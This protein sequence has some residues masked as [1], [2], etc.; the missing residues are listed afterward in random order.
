MPKSSAINF[1]DQSMGKN[2][3]EVF[4]GEEDLEVEDIIDVDEPTQ[5]K[6]QVDRKQNQHVTNIYT[7]NNINNFII[8]SPVPFIQNPILGQAQ[9]VLLHPN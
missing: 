2:G 1:Y 6:T 5:L 4:S 9:T 7:N 8:N 3:D